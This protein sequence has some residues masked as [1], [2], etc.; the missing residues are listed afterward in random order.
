MDKFEQRLALT[1]LCNL[2]RGSP[3]N[4]RAVL[5]LTSAVNTVADY[6]QIDNDE[7]HG[8]G[9]V[10]PLLTDLE[11]E[12]PR[13]RRALIT[14]TKKRKS[15]LKNAR[16]GIVE[17]NLRRL[18]RFFRLDQTDAAILGAIVRAGLGDPWEELL[19][20]SMNPLR[21]QGIAAAAG[22]TRIALPMVHSRLRATAPLCQFGIITVDSDGDISVLRKLVT[23]IPTQ[24]P[25]SEWI[26]DCSSNADRFTDGPFP[27]ESDRTPLPIRHYHR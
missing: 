26:A 20:S 25:K 17:T 3:H 12:D 16:P 5:H 14:R 23:M 18:A 19:G 8:L 9:K 15:E 6:V 7:P 1:M 27:S 4:H 21:A 13:H 22:A 10:L 2:L 11:I 24:L